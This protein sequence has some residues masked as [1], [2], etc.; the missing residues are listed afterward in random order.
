MS[1]T[2]GVT[3]TL[4]LLDILQHRGIGLCPLVLPS[5][6]LGG[7]NINKNMDAD[8]HSK[9]RCTTRRSKADESES[10]E[11][12]TTPESQNFPKFIIIIPTGQKTISDL[13]PFRIQ[14]AL[15]ASIG[16]VTSVRKTQ[17]GHLLIQTANAHYSRKLLALTDLAGVPVRAEPHQTL[18]SCKG[19]IRCS[20]LKG[21]TKDEIV[22]G[23]CS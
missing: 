12:S 6:E 15:Q 4:S 2:E 16:T 10:E 1:S 13:S 14:K 17:A 18:N 22:D 9:K 11:C 19:V 3:I 21:L 23:L 20:D 7:T 5:Y 8:P